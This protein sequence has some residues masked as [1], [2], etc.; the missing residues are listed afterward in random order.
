[1]DKATRTRIEN[2][3]Y[4]FMA[5][6]VR[7]VLLWFAIALILIGINFYYS[8]GYTC[9]PALHTVEAG[10]TLDGIAR[11]YCEG[12]VSDAVDYLVNENGGATIYIGQVI[13]LPSKG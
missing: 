12:R 9:F 13:A 1:M 2:E 7:R 6:H 8:E 10:D 4:A 11:Q 5:H 3:H